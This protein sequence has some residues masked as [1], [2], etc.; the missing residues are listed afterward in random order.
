MTGEPRSATVLAREHCGVLMLGKEA[1][2]STLE[3]D[4][5]IAEELSRALA[6]RR[7]DTHETLE[8][9]RDKA[10]SDARARDEQTFLRRIRTF[11]SLS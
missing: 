8:E 7:E 2:A 4:P 6:A 3:A 9:R 1:L 10:A 11:F 5:R